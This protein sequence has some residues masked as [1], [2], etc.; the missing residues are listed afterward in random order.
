MMSSVYKERFPKA[1]NQME[2]SIQQFILNNA[3]LS[4]FTTSVQLNHRPSSPNPSSFM[5]F[6]QQPTQQQHYPRPSSPRPQSPCPQRPI[7]PLVTESATAIGGGAVI[8]SSSSQLVHHRPLAN[9]GSG[10]GGET[11]PTHNTNISVG[12]NNS[13]PPTLV[14]SSCSTTTTTSAA[15]AASAFVY[16]DG[17]N[18]GTSGSMSGGEGTPPTSSSSFSKQQ[19][20]SSSRDATI[21]AAAAAASSQQQVLQEQVGRQGGSNNNDT[22]DSVSTT[23]SSTQ[24]QQSLPRRRSR[25]GSMVTDP[26]LNRIMSEGA[27]RFLH[28]Q[29]CEIAADC[30]QKSRDDLLTCAYF[31]NLSIRLDE[32]LAEVSVVSISSYME[33]T[34]QY[35][36]HHLIHLGRDQGRS[37]LV[38]VSGPTRQTAA[39]D[40]GQ[41]CPFA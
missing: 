33:Y 36:S 20:Q 17:G 6:A 16:G 29:L 5:Q 25:I 24:Q 23:T 26:A 19:Q 28:H 12:A 7:S 27:T 4:G 3:P 14:P 31:C 22:K 32:T 39:D 2:T 38:Q 10:G 41:D 1:K 18:N 11:T 9:T 13:V 15:A 34:P 21:P 30:L 8:R 37:R 40:C 35:F